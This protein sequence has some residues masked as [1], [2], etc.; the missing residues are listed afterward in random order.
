MRTVERCIREVQNF[1]RTV[2]FEAEAKLD[3]DGWEWLIGHATWTMARLPP[4]RD[5][6]TPDFDIAAWQLATP[7][8]REAHELAGGSPPRM[9]IST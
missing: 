8:E 2:R 3:D 6:P 1:V 7:Y 4:R 9:C 5:G